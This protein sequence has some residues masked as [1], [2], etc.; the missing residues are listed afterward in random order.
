MKKVYEA[1]SFEVVEVQIEK[2]FALSNALLTPP[3]LGEDVEW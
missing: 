1:P 3:E 2:G